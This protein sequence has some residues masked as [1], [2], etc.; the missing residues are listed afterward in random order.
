[1]CDCVCLNACMGE[2]TGG[3]QWA[4]KVLEVQLQ[5]TVNRA[6]WMLATAPAPQQE[7][8]VLLT[9]E[10][11]LLHFPFITE[12]PKYPFI[13]FLAFVNEQVRCTWDREGAGLHRWTESAKH[14]AY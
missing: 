4:Q 9:T 13:D 1:M 2:R 6:L 12:L 3:G 8:Q 10:R 11:S 14:M 5:G 7:Q